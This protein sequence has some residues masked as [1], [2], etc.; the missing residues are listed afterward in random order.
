M[1]KN[2]GQMPERREVIKD[3]DISSWGVDRD[4]IAKALNCRRSQQSS[5]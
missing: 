1:S 5:S 3:Q 2:Q 4:I